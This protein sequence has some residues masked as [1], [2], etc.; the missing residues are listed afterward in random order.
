VT[1][2]IKSEVDALIMLDQIRRFSETR[3]E[4]AKMLPAIEAVCRKILARYGGR[5]RSNRWTYTAAP[6]GSILITEVPSLSAVAFD[7]PIAIDDAA[8]LIPTS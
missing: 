3:A 5:A 6:D 8:E 7:E 4:Q 2:Y 1:R